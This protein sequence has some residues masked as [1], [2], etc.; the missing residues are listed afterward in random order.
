MRK[1]FGAVEKTFSQQV[2]IIATYNEDG[3]VDAMNAAWG[4]IGNDKE[5]F[6]CLSAD[7]RTCKNFERTGAFT[8]SM[9]DADHIA[10]CDF[11]GMVSGNDDP[12][13]FRKSGFTTTPSTLVDA[14]IINEL[15]VCVECKVKSWDPENC[16]LFGEIV[17]VS[18]D[19]NA[20]T[21]GN[22]DVDKVKPII[23]NPFD[24]S[25]HIVG[26][27]VGNA[28]KDGSALM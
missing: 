25:Y 19:E 24:H 20:L 2:F 4:G 15:A 11:V 21:N 23:F 12:E 28:F 9:G 13:K 27:K 17:N 8:V 22:V 7:H 14:P 3:T 1:S 10:A 18:V 16:H 5:I 26:K 6:I